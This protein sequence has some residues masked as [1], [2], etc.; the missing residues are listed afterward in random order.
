MPGSTASS[1]STALSRSTSSSTPGTLLSGITHDGSPGDS[2]PAPAILNEGGGPHLALVFPVWP[3][4][5][6]PR[7]DPDQG[8]ERRP[9]S[10]GNECSMVLRNRSVAGLGGRLAAYTITSSRPISGSVFPV[11]RCGWPTIVSGGTRAIP[12][13]CSTALSRSAMV[14]A[15]K[16]LRRWRPASSHATSIR[17]RSA[18]SERGAGRTRP[19]YDEAPSLTETMKVAIS[20]P[21]GVPEQQRSPR[22]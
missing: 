20:R 19:P 13:P 5:L 12:M 14:S 15:S 16:M 7:W 1:S 9:P 22:G 4:G 21:R 17:A 18:E 8:S 2:F 10:L 3:S 6:D 11:R